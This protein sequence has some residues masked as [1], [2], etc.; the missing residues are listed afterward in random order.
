MCYNIYALKLRGIKQALRF[1]ILTPDERIRLLKE[2]DRIEKELL[3][4]ADHRNNRLNGFEHPNVHLIINQNSEP[5]LLKANWGL[6][7]YW[8]KD[9]QQANDICNKTLNARGESIFEKP[10]FRDSARSKRCLVI[11]DGFF[12]HRHYKGKTYP[13]FINMKDGSP[14]IIGGLWSKW[15]GKKTG[16]IIKTFTIITTDANMLMS[17][18]HNKKKRMPL[19]LDP[20]ESDV[21]LK[22]DSVDEIKDLIDPLEDDKLFAYT[23]RRFSGRDVANRDESSIAEAIYPELTE[24]GELF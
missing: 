8:V 15:T 19:I 4:G 14:M 1:G 9:T 21:W 18:I 11:V 13:Y 3:K 22:S 24:A 5:N 6:I 17:E 20:D 10:S 16:E 12:E 2:V 7:P 23:V